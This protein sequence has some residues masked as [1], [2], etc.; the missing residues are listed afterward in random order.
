[1]VRQPPRTT[2]SGST[3]TAPTG[4]TRP[5]RTA[6]P[7]T[8]RA[9]MQVRIPDGAPESSRETSTVPRS[10]AAGGWGWLRDPGPAGGGMDSDPRLGPRQRPGALARFLPGLLHARALG[11]ETLPA[12]LPT[13][14]EPGDAEDHPLTGAQGDT[15]HSGSTASRQHEADAFVPST[16]GQGAWRRPLTLCRSDLQTGAAVRRTSVSPGPGSGRGTSTVSTVVS[17]RHTTACA[18]SVTISVIG[19]HRPSGRAWAGRPRSPARHRHLAPVSPGPARGA[20]RRPAALP[21]M[22]RAEVPARRWRA[23]RMWSRRRG[24][25]GWR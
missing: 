15:A 17:P 14:T 21:R 6:V 1:M 8:P 9:S 11:G 16:G 13:A 10:P 4:A 20:A 25:G 3:S 22:H 23:A 12:G 19:S 24:R 18:A 7:P 5:T 2:H